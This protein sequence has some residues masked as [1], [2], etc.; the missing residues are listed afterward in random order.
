MSQESVDKWPCKLV[1]LERYMQSLRLCAYTFTRTTQR[2]RTDTL[3]LI[4]LAAIS[5]DCIRISMKIGQP[6]SHIFSIERIDLKP[7][8]FQVRHVSA[9]G[10]RIFTPNIPDVGTVRLRYPVMPFH[11]EGNNIYK[12]L[13]A[14]QDITMDMPAF[15]KMF[16]KSPAFSSAVSCGYLAYNPSCIPA[17]C[18]FLLFVG[19]LS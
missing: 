12:N 5:Q 14:L 6:I 18:I 11:E 10:I 7:T 19:N 3:D 8:L 16:E 17:V 9:S 15:A 2:I 4:L 13:I 1:T